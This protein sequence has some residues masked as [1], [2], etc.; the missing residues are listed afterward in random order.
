MI[1]K[2]WE[3]HVSKHFFFS[4]F[5]VFYLN[6]EFEEKISFHLKKIKKKK[7]KKILPP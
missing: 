7:F 5:L 6:T 2:F 1:K 4:A 3:T